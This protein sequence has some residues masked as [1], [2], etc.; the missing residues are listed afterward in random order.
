MPSEFQG[1]FWTRL[2]TLREALQVIAQLQPSD[3]PDIEKIL[4]TPSVLSPSAWIQHIGDVAAVAGSLA[5]T[6]P[7]L[8]EVYA[9]SRRE[10]ITALHTITVAYAFLS[11][12]HS[13]LTGIGISQ[14]SST[15]QMRSP[16]FLEFFGL[17]LPAPTVAASLYENLEKI[18]EPTFGHVIGGILSDLQIPTTKASRPTITLNVINDATARYLDGMR[19]LAIDIPEFF[20]WM[21]LAENQRTRDAIAE[22]QPDAIAE[23]RQDF[24]GLAVLASLLELNPQTEPSSPNDPR[25]ELQRIHHAELDRPL[26]YLP[27]EGIYIP[28]VR[29]GFINPAFR[30]VSVL[31]DSPVWEQSF[32]D[33]QPVR[34]DLDLTLAAYLTSVEST[35]KPMMILGQPGSGKSLLLKVIAGRLPA[36]QFTVLRVPLRIVDARAPLYHQAQ[37]A[38]D[39][40]TNRRLDWSDLSV[41]G[42]TTVRVLL[43]DGVDEL[44]VTGAG[45]AYY[46]EEIADFQRREAALGRPVVVIVTGRTVLADRIHIPPDALVVM[47]EPFNDRRIE[48]WLN[49]W[50]SANS[51]AIAHGKLVAISVKRALAV[52]ELAEQPILLIMLALYWAVNRV[53]QD[54]RSTARLYQDLAENLVRREIYRENVP[55]ETVDMAVTNEL[56]RLGLAALGAFNRGG[57]G[58]DESDLHDDIAAISPG[59]TSRL[60]LVAGGSAP[61]ATRTLLGRFFFIHQSASR[62][63]GENRHYFEFLHATFGEYFV[64]ASLVRLLREMALISEVRAR[65]DTWHQP[66]SDDLLHALLS[67][68]LL[69]ARPTILSFAEELVTDLPAEI[70]QEIASLLEMLMLQ[71]RLNVQHSL[72]TEY[73]PTSRNAITAAAAYSA[74]LTLLR[75]FLFPAHLGV[76]VDLINSDTADPMS[77]WGA[78]VRLWGSALNYEEWTSII[79]ALELVDGHIARRKKLLPR[80]DESIYIAE[81][82]LRGEPELAHALRVGFGAKKANRQA[83]RSLGQ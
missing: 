49:I 17:T 4:V 46:L 31:P 8:A 38:L 45:R 11:A 76:S 28:T 10:L 71:A 20:V 39:Y 50:N 54:A 19:Q 16:G 59:P 83:W 32:W 30:M 81:A 27:D 78:V 35:L 77:S 72:Y 63:A 61:D 74:N 5:R 34:D 2:Q 64:A 37:Q 3:R 23:T 57:V 56:W 36:S 6:A 42:N 29:H 51:S 68:R 47:I 80:D 22:A 33:M 12:T 18:L 55:Q 75:A 82:D 58:V 70:Q 73:R 52:R 15:S 44:I 53:D 25:M 40:M 48:Q 65:H 69:S 24:T 41:F 43:L 13:A 26:I 7:R 60:Y 1:Q 9:S 67:H 21:S 14:S 62:H 66:T 79:G